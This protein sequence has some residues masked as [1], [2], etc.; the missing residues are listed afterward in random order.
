M[1]ERAV[2]SKGDIVYREGSFEMSMYRIISGK[3]AV[4]ASYGEENETLLVEQGEKTYFGQLELIEAI[5]RSATVVA[6]EA[7]T[8]EKIMGDEFGAYLS[9]HP[10]ESMV[11]LQQ[12]S[13]RLRDIG[14]Q[15][16]EVYHT[17]DEYISEDAG[18]H[19]ESFIGRLARI[20]R[21]G[22]GVGQR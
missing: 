14:D 2:F 20:I 22:K 5:P 1:S 3:I 18:A 12:L 10:G 4:Y 7:L 8:A 11:L 15:L 16:H 9:A 13:A 17:I 19:D 21:L 6:T